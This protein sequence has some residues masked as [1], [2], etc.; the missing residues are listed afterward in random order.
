MSETNAMGAS[1]SGSAL[2]CPACGA[3]VAEGR[4]SC[5]EC[6]TLMASVSG[7]PTS[8]SVDAPAPSAE[9]PV[10]RPAPVPAP[11]PQPAPTRPGPA[12][13]PSARGA[14]AL[15]REAVVPPEARPLPQGQWYS[16]RFRAAAAGQPMGAE[17]ETPA[18]ARAGSAGLF[19]DLPIAGPPV[20]L[21]WAS[22]VG[23]WLLV[24]AFLLPW[25]PNLDYFSAWGVGVGRNFIVLIA[26]VVVAI[27]TVLPLRIPASLR[28]GLLPL[29]L[30][31]FCLGLAWYQLSFAQAPQVG[32]WLFLVGGILAAGG[33]G[34]MVLRPDDEPAGDAA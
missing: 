19:S 22:I 18:Q 13:E 31:A 11:P 5:P 20:A 16:E 4:L 25:A 17:A 3:A 33:G 7:R 34:F 23:S 10:T 24:L 21:G 8:P 32:F 6:G 30:G 14:V 27:L 28:L 1:G 26:S 29:L 2:T 9:R 15:P 12:L